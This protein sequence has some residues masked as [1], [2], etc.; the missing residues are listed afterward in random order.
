MEKSTTSQKTLAK[1]E[2]R[3]REMITS[4]ATTTSGAFA[5][6]QRRRHIIERKKTTTTKRRVSSSSSTSSSG[7]AFASSSSSSSDDDDEKKRS[8]V[9]VQNGKTKKK[10]CVITGANTG[11]GYETALA[12]L[13]KDYKVIAA[14]RDVKKMELARESLME[15][16]KGTEDVEI[17]I[18]AMDLSDKKSIEAFAKKFMDSTTL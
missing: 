3:E 16:L 1:E 10:T 8:D 18:E 11:I 17:V 14:V 15:K 9:G 5:A 13:Q 4:I 6:A 12:M 7:V 2:E